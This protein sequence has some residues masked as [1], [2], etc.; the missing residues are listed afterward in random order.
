MKLNLPPMVRVSI[1][2]VSAFGT[3]VVTYLFAKEL[4]GQLEVSLWGAFVTV[5]NTM[6]ALN[7]NPEENK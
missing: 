7:V 6:A 5:A 2:V 3:P 4:V 1:Y